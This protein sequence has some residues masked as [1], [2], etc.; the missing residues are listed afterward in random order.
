MEIKSEI[1]FSAAELLCDIFSFFFFY[2][3]LFP[4]A[5]GDITVNSSQRQ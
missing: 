3:Y 5:A 4:R 2:F 1:Q